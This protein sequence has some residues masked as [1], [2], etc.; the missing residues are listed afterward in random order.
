M[1]IAKG[2]VASRVDWLQKY[3]RG[4]RQRETKTKRCP[5]SINVTLL[6]RDVGQMI[7]LWVWVKGKEAQA[8]T[9]QL[10]GQQIQ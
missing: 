2:F 4:K 5:K 6:R 8:I 3:T 10:K 7:Q 9:K 1:R